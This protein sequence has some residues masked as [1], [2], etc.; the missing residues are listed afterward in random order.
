MDLNEFSITYWVRKNQNPKWS[1][2][3]SIIN[4]KPMN[5]PN[6]ILNATRKIGNKYLIYLLN[7]E[8]GNLKIEESIK[9]YLEKDLFVAITRKET[10]LKLY[11]NT[12]LKKSVNISELKNNTPQVGDFVMVKIANGDL[13]NFKT[14]VET[15]V[16]AILENI[17]GDNYTFFFWEMNQRVVLN[18]NKIFSK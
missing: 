18:K 8:F 3:D 17:H 1:D 4:F 16:P 2:E 6:G 12:D 10:E 9:K 11:F 5:L 15:L 14:N 13:D 7:P